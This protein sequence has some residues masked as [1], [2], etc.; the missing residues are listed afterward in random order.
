MAGRTGSL[1]N[2]GSVHARPYLAGEDG[3]ARRVVSWAPREEQK[4]YAPSDVF[5]TS[6]AW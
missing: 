2:V 5:A 4:F 6:L 3:A 1:P